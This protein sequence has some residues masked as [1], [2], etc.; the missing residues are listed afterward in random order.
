[1]AATLFLSLIMAGT[2][3]RF[4]AKPKPDQ[5]GGIENVPARRKIERKFTETAASDY[6][7]RMRQAS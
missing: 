4:K 6:M 7:M 2:E 1:M 3:Y 5:V